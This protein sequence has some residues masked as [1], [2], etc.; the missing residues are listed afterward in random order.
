MWLLFL[1]LIVVC[2]GSGKV[3][4]WV[5][6]VIAVVLALSSVSKGTGMI[7][8]WPKREPRKINDESF[9]EWS[10]GSADPG[11]GYLIHARIVAEDWVLSRWGRKAAS[12]YAWAGL[13]IA[14]LSFCSFLVFEAEAL[15]PHSR[16]PHM[17]ASD[18]LN[19]LFVVSLGF[20]AYPFIKPK[21]TSAKSAAGVIREDLHGAV[22]LLAQWRTFC[23][24]VPLPYS[25]WRYARGLLPVAGWAYH[26]FVS[27]GHLLALT[28]VVGVAMGYF[29]Y[30]MVDLSF[31]VLAAVNG[32][33]VC[34]CRSSFL[35]RLVWESQFLFQRHKPLWAKF[36]SWM[37]I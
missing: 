27:D 20:L 33:E 22:V 21:T 10:D 13:L 14:L 7:W 16:Y 1:V 15:F 3:G 36:V 28:A 35:A 37:G 23:G 34:P 24:T 11:W 32:V 29:A 26:R 5:A 12:W 9:P 2:L 8:P 17:A 4:V 6:A 18:L 31:D 25:F 19:V 30:V